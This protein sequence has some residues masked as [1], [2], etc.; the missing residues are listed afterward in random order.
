MNSKKRR[1][2]EQNKKLTY[3]NLIIKRVSLIFIVTE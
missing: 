1:K 3:K 2:R